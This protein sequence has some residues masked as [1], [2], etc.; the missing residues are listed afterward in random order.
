MSPGNRNPS[1]R[2]DPVLS[3]PCPPSAALHRR[4][5]RASSRNTG[6]GRRVDR[7]AGATDPRTRGHVGWVARCTGAR[8]ED[9]RSRRRRLRSAPAVRLSSPM[10]VSRSSMLGPYRA[11][12]RPENTRGSDGQ[13]LPGSAGARGRSGERSQPVTRR[14]RETGLHAARPHCVGLGL[15]GQVPDA[16]PPAGCRTGVSENSP[17]R[18]PLPPRGSENGGRLCPPGSRQRPDRAAPSRACRDR[19]APRR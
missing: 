18:L 8:V 6:A 3:R 13:H 14:S 16:D 5:R 7:L 11:S 10:V 12:N 19:R 15:A 1:S 17:E 2:S 9:E 4:A